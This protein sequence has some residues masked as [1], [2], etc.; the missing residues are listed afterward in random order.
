[1]QRKKNGFWTFI[2]SLIPG[3]GEM[4]LGFFKQGLSLMTVF[5]GLIAM[6]AL[7][8]LDP[9]IY[10]MPIVWFYSFFHVHNLHGMPDEEFYAV[11]DQ[12]IFNLKDTELKET[13]GG[14]RGRKVLA[15]CLIFIGIFALMPV[16]S[17]GI[18]DALFMFGLSGIAEQ[19]SGY[20][21]EIPQLVIA[22]ALIVL[23]VHL[24]K[25]K[26]KKLDKEELEMKDVNQA[27]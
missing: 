16:I 22:I 15:W 20:M 14:E 10:V 3:A 11:E 19:L 8:R 21:Y 5:W 18:M 7:V 25:G 6:I 26:K 27:E 17:N 4:Y 24:I 1:M 2:F 23:G 13:L 12:Y 9:L